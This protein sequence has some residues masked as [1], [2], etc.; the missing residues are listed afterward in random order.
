M[1][2]WQSTM[3]GLIS[4][5]LGGHYTGFWSLPKLSIRQDETER[6]SCRPF[7][8][9][10][11]DQS[12]PQADNPLLQA[13]SL[14][15][16]Q[17][18][19]SRFSKKDIDSLSVAVVSSDGVLFE[20]NYGVMRGNE[21]ESSPVTNSDSMYRIASVS[22]LFTVLEGHILA[23]KGVISWDDRVDKYLP[24]FRIRSDESSNP[25]S[26]SITLFQ[27]ASHMSG[28][29]RDWPP[30][31]VANWPK[32]LF[33]A[34]PP[35]TNGLPFP[36]HASLF[37]ALKKNA[38]VSH[39]FAIPGYS[40]T[41]IGVLGL[42]LVAANRAANGPK[43]PSSYADLLK[44]DIFDPLGLNGSHFLTTE[45][46]KDLVVV[47]S[48]AP[49]VADQDFLD[50]MNPAGGQFSS[51]RDSITV[52]QTLLNPTD[53]R[54]LISKQTMDSWMHT[55]HAF[56]EDDWTEIGFLWE[57]IKARDSN[58][59]LRKIYWKLGAMAGYHA[60][61]AIHP[62]TSYGVAVLLGGHYP[63]AAKIAYDIFDIFQP[64]IDKSLAELVTSVY[65]G[66]WASLDKNSSATVLIDRG[67]LYVDNLFVDG[68]D[69]L[70]KF[71]SPHR[72]SLRSTNRDKFR[73]DIGIPFYNGKIHMGCYPYWVGMDLWGM[74]DGHALNAIEFSGEGTGRRLHLPAI[75]VEMIRAK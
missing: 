48:L 14:R 16:A 37:R 58:G 69:I 74:R 71:N 57:I 32:D 64:A 15:A 54:S 1:Q 34:G 49:E 36:D 21:S 44:R 12:P 13:A 41:G 23:E 56:E 20:G 2:L 22:K 31:N 72:V 65:V 50:A 25:S 61:L 10:L 38:L 11:F 68:T 6:F 45:S 51:L 46:N 67:T 62:G 28:L 18:L 17:F 5:I 30:G 60:A 24:H 35:P 75:G 70:A 33:G 4:L 26:T 52:L 39:P 43:E 29:G 66:K 55:F 73:L 42:A 53:K 3:V 27:L 8:P 9:T 19:E 59:R 7:L 63:D 40:N 47:P